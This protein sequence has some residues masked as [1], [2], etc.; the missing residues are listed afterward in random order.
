MQCTA[1]ALAMICIV[2]VRADRKCTKSGNC[3]PSTC[4]PLEVP[5]RGKP[6]RDSF[7]R[8]LFTPTWELQK[9]RTCVCK[10]GYLRNSWGECIP[11]KKCIPCKFRWQRDYRTCAPGCPATCNVPFSESCNKPCSEGCDCP[12]GY[13]VHPKLSKMCIKADKCLPKCPANSSFQACVSSCRPK[14]GRNPPKNCDTNCDTG[15]CICN[16]GYAEL[17]QGGKK[18]CVLQGMCSRYSRTKP[19]LQSNA[20]RYTAGGAP[21]PVPT[22]LTSNTSRRPENVGLPV[23]QGQAPTNA[24]TTLG[25]KLPSGSGAMSS[26]AIT[27]GTGGTLS[28]VATGTDGNVVHTGS[29][30]TRSSVATVEPSTAAGTASVGTDSSG[31]T[32]LTTAVRENALPTVS[33]ASAGSAV[34]PITEGATSQKPGGHLSL[35][36]KTSTLVAGTLS[37]G[38]ASL[39]GAAAGSLA[40][41]TH[42]AVR[43]GTGA[44]AVGFP[45]GVPAAPATEGT[46]RGGLETATEGTSSRYAPGLHT[47]VAPNTRGTVTDGAPGGAQ[48]S[49]HAGGSISV[50]GAGNEANNLSS[51]ATG[52]EEAAITEN[53][54]PS[55]TLLH[56]GGV[57]EAGIVGTRPNF[58]TEL[59]VAGT[60]TSPVLGPVP[61]STGNGRNSLVMNA[62]GEPL[63]TAA[64]YGLTGVRPY[65]QGRHA[66]VNPPVHGT[67]FW[68]NPWRTLSPAR[69]VYPPLQ[70]RDFE[71]YP[72][73]AP[74]ISP[75]GHE[76]TS[77]RFYPWCTPSLF[78]TGLRTIGLKFYPWGTP[79]GGNVGHGLAGFEVYPW[80]SSLGFST[81]PHETSFGFDPW[82]TL[83]RF[84]A[85][86]VAA[87]SRF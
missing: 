60:A 13:V 5:V 54:H 19:L 83:S 75:L 25:G 71:Y 34:V 29:E 12:P 44:A 28:P 8:P 39:V 67:G 6:Q 66:H 53:T 69:V 16:K 52:L 87:V 24:G 27:I 3:G 79:L 9:L 56:R 43:A 17:E 47:Q 11:R 58:T 20:T 46:L 51:G 81:G 23:R 63:G 21:S 30:G 4:G 26:T 37:L 84:I 35:T 68:F 18:T 2:V 72:W 86:N 36:N 40:T 45:T 10:R 49:V 22:N 65:R 48:P 74:F 61:I 62:Q 57:V 38:T 31:T 7:C 85:P 59:P 77:F 41:G 42:S 14:C 32:D 50:N 55:I 80:G 1:V 73:R 33:L 64:W 15:A 82:G 78:P 70:P 76:S